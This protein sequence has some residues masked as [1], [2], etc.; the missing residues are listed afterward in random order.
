[1]SK[2]AELDILM[3]KSVLELSFDEALLV[4]EYRCSK[5][6]QGY[7]AD[8]GRGTH[9]AGIRDDQDIKILYHTLR[10]DRRVEADLILDNYIH[11]MVPGFVQPLLIPGYND[12]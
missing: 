11:K 5:Y 4:L 6:K 7:A 10:Y 1:M 9:S 2:M 12:E 8:I 3:R